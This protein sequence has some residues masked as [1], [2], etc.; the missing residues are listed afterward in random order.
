MRSNEEKFTDK[1]MSQK[2]KLGDSPVCEM[3]PTNKIIRLT[4]SK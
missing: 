2:D 4:R 3:I 1:F